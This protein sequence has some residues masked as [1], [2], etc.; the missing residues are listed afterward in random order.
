MSTMSTLL[1]GT[2]VE[3]RWLPWEVV[4][5]EPA[6]EQ[7]RLRLRCL[8]GDFQGMEIDLLH[9]FEAMRPI[10]TDLN[11]QR[12]G[13]LRGASGRCWPSSRSSSARSQQMM[14]R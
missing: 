1:P 2:Q 12:A 10:A 14:D 8:Q 13:R 11:P 4:H 9:P 5:A 6:G 7:H 3:A